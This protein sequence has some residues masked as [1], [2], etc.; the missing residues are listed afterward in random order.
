MDHNSLPRTRADLMARI[1]RDWAAL[2]ETIADLIEEQMSVPDAGGW[3][4][5]DNL[6]HLT[7]W[8]STGRS[9]MVLRKEGLPMP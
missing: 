3:S 7:A 8:E 2:E 6:A 5:K 9:L 4:I 1:Q